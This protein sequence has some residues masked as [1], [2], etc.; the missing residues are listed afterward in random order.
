LEYLAHK[1]ALP[2][3]TQ[4]RRFYPFVF[5]RND[6][7][8]GRR[9]PLNRIKYNEQCD[10]ETGY[11][12]LPRQ[13][14]QAHHGARY[15]DHELM[16]MWLSVDPMADKYP[17][18]SP[19]A[20]C[21]WNPVRLIDPDGMDIWI[22]N[23]A[24]SFQYTVGMSPD[25]YEGFSKQAITSLNE[26]YQTDEGKL[27]LDFLVDADIVVEISYAYVTENYLSQLN[28]SPD[29]FFNVETKMPGTGL[30]FSCDIKWNSAESGGQMCVNGMDKNITLDLA[31]EIAHA[32]DA[33]NGW[34]YRYEEINGVIVDEGLVNGYDK[35]E[36]QAAY[37]VNV[38][39]SQMGN[40][41]YRTTYFSNPT[42]ANKET[43]FKPSW[44]TLKTTD[45]ESRITFD[46][47]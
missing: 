34:A 10:E 8:K 27:M 13:A 18:I 15:M 25:G 19:Y 43:F 40:T 35:R 3:R 24:N 26:I 29:A 1:T 28:G 37:R 38:I 20:Y 9:I 33:G 5:T 41:N 36:F 39:R 17:S 47:P 4:T 7:R 30:G 21:A 12:Y 42:I 44:Y 2:N 22:I 14:R 16:T 46:I 11:G 23:G 32:Y 45:N 6:P 31:D